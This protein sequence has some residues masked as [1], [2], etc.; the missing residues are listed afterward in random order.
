MLEIGCDRGQVLASL[1]AAERVGVDYN[2]AAIE[3]GKKEFPE[4]P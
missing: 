2:S 3:A 1:N 4:L